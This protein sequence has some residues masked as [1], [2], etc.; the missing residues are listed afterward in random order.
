[1]KKWSYF[2]WFIFE[3]TCS[4][5]FEKRSVAY[6]FVVELTALKFF[7]NLISYISQDMRI[8]TYIVYSTTL[9]T[10]YHMIRHSTVT[11]NR[12]DFL[13]PS[14]LSLINTNHGD[15]LR[16][17][18][19]VFKTRHNLFQSGYDWLKGQT[20]SLLLK[21]AKMQWFINIS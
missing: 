17:C 3:I 4:I 2:L 10:T 1:M 6:T 12:P 19:A 11:L 5:L 15:R 16:I 18:V 9:Y 20:C 14:P 21:C 8:P 13:G 7:G